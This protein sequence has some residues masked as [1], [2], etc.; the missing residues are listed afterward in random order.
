MAIMP[1]AISIKNKNEII[2]ILEMCLPQALSAKNIPIRTK[3]IIKIIKSPKPSPPPSL[4]LFLQPHLR[5]Q[6]H[7]LQQS[8]QQIQ[9]P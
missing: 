4:P 2:K 6:S 5:S 1:I 9:L 7:L 8:S 3:I